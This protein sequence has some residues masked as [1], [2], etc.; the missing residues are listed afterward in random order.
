M[1]NY[2]VIVMN[3]TLNYINFQKTRIIHNSTTPNFKFSTPEVHHTQREEKVVK[4]RG[5]PP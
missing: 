4:W 3:L 1:F 2:N 5:R